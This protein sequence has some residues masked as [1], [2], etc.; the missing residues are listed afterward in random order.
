MIQHPFPLPQ[1]TPNGL[2][3]CP[4]RSCT[5]VGVARSFA[6]AE[7]AL[8]EHLIYHEWLRRQDGDAA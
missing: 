6:A 8:V 4:C 5:F 3:L 7:A 1:P 2:A